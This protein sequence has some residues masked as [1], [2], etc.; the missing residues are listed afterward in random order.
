[1]YI[2]TDLEKMSSARLKEIKMQL[3]VSTK[4]GMLGDKDL[5]AQLQQVKDELN[6]REHVPRGKEAKIYRRYMAQTGIKDVMEIQK[7]FGKKIA[8]ELK[9]C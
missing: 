6:T 7:Q 8:E 3:T 4:N 2:P 9:Q 5:E 1:M